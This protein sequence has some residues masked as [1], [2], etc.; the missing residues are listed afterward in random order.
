MCV[1]TFCKVNRNSLR[2]CIYK[3]QNIPW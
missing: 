3:N 2:L 1:D